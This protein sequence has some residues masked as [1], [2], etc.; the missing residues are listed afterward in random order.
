MGYYNDPQTRQSRLKQNKFNAGFFG[1]IGAVIGAAA[2]LFVAPL[3]DSGEQTAT[4]PEAGDK[5]QQEAG[6]VV[7]NRTN[8]TSDVTEAV[9]TASG[10]VVGV[11]NLQQTSFF[12]SDSPQDLGAGSGVVYKEEG[13]SAFIVTN[14]HV[15]DGAS[16]VEV[17]IDDNDRVEAEIVGSDE[18][19]DLAV[20]RVGAEH[21]TTVVSFGDSTQLNVGEPAIAIGNPLGPDLS[22]T[23][24]QGIISALDRSIPVD[25]DGDG[26]EDW[27]SEVLQTDAAINP[28]N[29][30]GALVDI[31]GELIGIN[32]MKISQSQVEGIGFAIPTNV[33][34]P[35]LEDL[36]ESGQVERPQLGVTIGALQDIPSYHWQESLHLPEEVEHGVFI[37][38]VLDGSAAA[39]AGL[40]E[41]DVITALDGKEIENGNQLRSFLYN[42]KNIGDNVEVTFYRN[43]E[44][45][46]ADLT[47]AVQGTNQQ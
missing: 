35:V 39:E 27:E 26:V 36:E 47:L 42:E 23:V 15:I 21:I 28:G 45:Q 25:L 20:L 24:T 30:G 13:D 6:E 9:E 44:Q 19:T 22:G 17:S 38:S 43:G 2:V 5:E 18:L 41:Y 4:E 31:N 3:L 14:H 1:F 11:F 8:V 29:S 46:T 12:E 37:T 40:Q 32:S 34:I 16:Q 33:A 7:E 10:A